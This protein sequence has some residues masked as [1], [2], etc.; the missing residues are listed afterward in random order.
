MN[1]FWKIVFSIFGGCNVVISFFIPIAIVVL[2]IENVQMEGVFPTILIIVG[3]LA[4]SFRGI[5]VLMNW[6]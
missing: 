5:K 4:S 2:W 6:K 1:K 3:L